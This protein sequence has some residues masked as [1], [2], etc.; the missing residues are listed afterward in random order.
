MPGPRL[1]RA[2]IE[3][4]PHWRRDP[5]DNL[6]LGAIFNVDGQRY[7]V[8]FHD[9][10]PYMRID[11]LPAPVQLKIFAAW[12]DLDRETIKV[13]LLWPPTIQ[14]ILYLPMI[15]EALRPP[16]AVVAPSKAE[17]KSPLH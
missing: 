7:W 2:V 10:V 16:A 6:E 5:S 9:T 3:D 14:T 1:S 8:Q 13:G 17:P 4:Q 15:P 12:S 11:G